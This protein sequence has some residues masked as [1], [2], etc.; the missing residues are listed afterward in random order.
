MSERLK[1]L[2]HSAGRQVAEIACDVLSA[3]VI[4]FFVLKVIESI[5]FWTTVICGGFVGLILA[6]P[7]VHEK[8]RRWAVCPHRIRGGQTQNLR[9]TCTR[10]AK[11]I[12]ET[13]RRD[14]E[15]QEQR[16]RI[17]AAADDLQRRE[18][19]RLRPL[20]PRIGDFLSLHPRDFETLIAGMFE[21]LA[22]K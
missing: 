13:T 6:Y 22:S 9:E 17:E 15:L 7:A 4:I 16:E 1:E 11:E 10:I 12:E 20:M 14:R 19:L 8:L 3:G 21:R 18:Q 5:G 2:L